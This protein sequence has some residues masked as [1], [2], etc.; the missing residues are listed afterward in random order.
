[1]NYKFK[2]LIYTYSVKFIYHYVDN[3]GNYCRHRVDGPNFVQY[4][5]EDY[6]YKSYSL[7]DYL[8]VDYGN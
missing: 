2:C 3:M 1:M 7:N 4:I 8:M 5:N 6:Y